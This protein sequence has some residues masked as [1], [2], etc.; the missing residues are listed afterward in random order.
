MTTSFVDKVKGFLM[1]PT[2][3][4]QDSRADSLGA[5]FRYY[6]TLL[7]IFT[8]LYAIVS[9]AIGM[10]SFASMIEQLAASGVIGEALAGVLQNFSDFMVAMSLFFVY[11]LFILMLFGVFLEGFFYH[12]FV[13]LFGGTKGFVTTLKTVMYAYTPWFLLGWIPY[14]SVIG[15]LWTLI[16]LILGIKETQEMTLGDAL[17]VILVP[18][19]LVLILA[20]LGAVV[21]AALVAGIVEMLPSM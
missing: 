5:A 1:A 12:V 13:I 3:A 20:L 21:I 17:L 14:V 6:V 15:A 18:F 7:V 10:A 16:L 9:T 11:L 2:K 4:F 8:I 19:I